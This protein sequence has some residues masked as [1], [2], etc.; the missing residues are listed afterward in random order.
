MI[1]KHFGVVGLSIPGILTL[2]TSPDSGMNDLQAKSS[3][4]SCKY[5]QHDMPM[6]NGINTSLYSKG[7]EKVPEYGDR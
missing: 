4:R 5:K 2:L 1:C 3:K 7:T 6:V